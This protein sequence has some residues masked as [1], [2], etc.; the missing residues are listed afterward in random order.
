MLRVR[1]ALE[2]YGATAKA[3]FQSAAADQLTA[4]WSDELGKRNGLNTQQAGIVKAFPLVSVAGFAVVAGTGGVG[5]L[6][7]LTR[8]FEFGADREKFVTYF[9]RNRKSPGHH[10]VTRRTRRQLPG[11]SARGWIAYPSAGAWSS[12]VYSM[13]LQ[14]LVK[15]GHD[16]FEGKTRG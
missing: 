2:Q 16:A 10:Q 6:G 4:A 13:L 15:T 8:A 14:I 3:T 9:R 12:R 1:D 11:I 5:P 7:F